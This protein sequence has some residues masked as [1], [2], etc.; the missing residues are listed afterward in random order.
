M[1]P[2]DSSLVAALRSHWTRQ[3]TERLAAGPAWADEGFVFTDELGARL[4]PKHLSTRFETLAYNAGVRRIRLHD[5][6][7]SA[8]SLMLA[9]G[10]NVKA[11]AELLGHSS[12]TITQTIYQHVTPG[13][14]EAA[15]ER[16]SA[17]L[18][19]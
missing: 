13:M 14:S 11:V 2:L 19:G 16:L 5:L 17:A 9:S 15:G 7:H 1:I 8:A 3:A 4:H 18:L 10:E 12:P 6:R